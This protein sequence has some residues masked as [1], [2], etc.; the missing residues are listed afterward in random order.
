MHRVFALHF[1]GS[2]P[3]LF[4]DPLS[5]RFARKDY[6]PAGRASGGERG[7][8]SSSRWKVGCRL[9]QQVD[10]DR[11][12]RAASHLRRI[13]EALGLERRARDVTPSLAEYLASLRQSRSLPTCV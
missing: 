6:A 8:A 2:P 11:F 1:W 12:G 5:R 3:R 4:V 10:I 9:G 7:P 13:L